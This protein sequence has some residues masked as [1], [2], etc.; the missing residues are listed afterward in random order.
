LRPPDLTIGNPPQTLRWHL[1]Q[2][3]GFQLALHKWIKSDDD[4]ALHDHSAWSVSLLLT[5]C[6][7]EVFSHAWEPLRC[8]LRIPLIPVFRRSSTPHRVLL[9]SPRPIWTLWLRGPPW[10]EWGFCCPKGWRPWR[11][12]TAERDYSAPGS[13]STVGRGC[14][15]D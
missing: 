14:G 1:I 15:E 13:S 12:Y 11:Q 10:R 5:G 8:R 3:R 4:R 7:W 9:L 2:W 6:Y